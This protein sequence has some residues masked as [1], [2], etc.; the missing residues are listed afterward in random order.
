MA[1]AT[2]GSAMVACQSSTG[3]WLATIVDRKSP[4]Q[5]LH[6]AERDADVHLPPHQPVGHAVVV[7]LH[8]YVMVNVHARLFPAGELVPP[9]REGL[10][11]RLFQTLEHGLAATLQLAEGPAVQPRQSLPDSLVEQERLVTLLRPVVKS[12]CGYVSSGGIW[13]GTGTGWRPCR[14]ENGWA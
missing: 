6:G 13:N 11:R 1:S 12:R 5:Q 7:A 9:G 14:R 4:V 8:R 3:N 2:D 10:E